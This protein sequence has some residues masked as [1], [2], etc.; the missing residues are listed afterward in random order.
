MET[1][2]SVSGLLPEHQ[3]TG[4]SGPQAAPPAANPAD[5]DAEIHSFAA[6]LYGSGGT[7]P[8]TADGPN[9][10]EGS[11]RKKRQTKKSSRTILSDCLQ[12]A[13]ISSRSGNGSVA[14]TGRPDTIEDEVFVQSVPSGDSGMETGAVD[15][16]A[17]PSEYNII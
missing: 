3:A 7:A 1:D 5:A 12:T 10:Q 17:F 6:N 2:D 16:A 13:R 9:T 8:N 14:E 11:I 15:N 4:P